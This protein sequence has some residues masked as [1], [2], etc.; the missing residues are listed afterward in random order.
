MR[1]LRQTAARPQTSTQ[2]HF[3]MDL[4]EGI[5]E[6]PTDGPSRTTPLCTALELSRRCPRFASCSAA[7]CPAIGGVHLK[8]EQVCAWLLESRKVGGFERLDMQIDPQLVHAV[9]AVA[10]TATGSLAAAI[11]RAGLTPSRMRPVTRA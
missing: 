6:T 7:L 3:S 5:A 8:G 4:I 9:F 2:D 10:A 1:K 11:A